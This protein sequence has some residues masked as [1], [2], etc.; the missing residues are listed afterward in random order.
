MN[1]SIVIPTYKEKENLS[2]L[3]PIIESQ[4]NS[5]PFEIIIVDDNSNDGTRELIKNINSPNIN[6]IVRTNERG[7]SSAVHKGISVAKSKT[8]C[9]MDADFS[10]PPTALIPMYEMINKENYDLVVGSRLVR[11]GGSANWPFIRKFISWG[12]RQLA[13]PL[14][15]IKDITSGFFMFKK[16]IYPNDKL[17][18]NGF[19]IGLELAVKG[20]AKKIGECPIVFNDRKYG[21]SKLNSS[22]MTDYLKQ[23]AELY[24]YK[25]KR[26]FKR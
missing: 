25:F 14:T 5:I 9:F 13:K 8:I 10:H 4:V 20:S 11:G 3:L 7:L 23:L 15:P 17:N 12:A 24:S 6:L 2:E 22:I 26:I 1:L 21:Y 19:K 16:E 18:L